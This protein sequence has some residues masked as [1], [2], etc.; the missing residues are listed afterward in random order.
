MC[1]KASV[2]MTTGI[3]YYRGQNPTAYDVGNQPNASVVLA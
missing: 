2:N 1:A 3:T